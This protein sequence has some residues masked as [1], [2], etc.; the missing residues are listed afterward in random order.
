MVNTRRLT[1]KD[2]GLNVGSKLQDGPR[3]QVYMGWHSPFKWPY[4][5]EITGGITLYL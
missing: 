1:A 2:D 3:H 5:K 4:K